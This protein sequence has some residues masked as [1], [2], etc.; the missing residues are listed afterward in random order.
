MSLRR[1]HICYSGLRP[2]VLTFVASGVN[3]TSPGSTFSGVNFG[4]AAADRYLIAAF[5]YNS[6]TD[7]LTAT[8]GGAAATRLVGVNSPFGN[9]RTAIFIA[10]VPSGTSGTVVLSNGA[11]GNT[12]LALYS[13]TGL[14]SPTAV[15][16][17]TASGTP[18]ANLSVAVSAFGI[19]IVCGYSSGASSTATW[20]SL[21]A[22]DTNNRF[23]ATALTTA[24]NF[25][26]T[27][28][29]STLNTTF[30]YTNTSNVM[31]CCAVSLR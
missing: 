23:I 16:T 29:A 20:S 27:G 10:L 18:P 22:I 24:G 12:T 1:R 2:P 8:I 26:S 3:T 15:A 7:A 9:A 6:A 5:G 11:G 17:N 30:N 4:A 13:V 19:A 25:V 28:P 14:L 21:T 31:S